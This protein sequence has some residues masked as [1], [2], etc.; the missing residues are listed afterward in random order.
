MSVGSLDIEFMGASW[1]RALRAEN[2]SPNTLKTYH[3]ALTQFQRFLSHG[4]PPPLLADI[5]REDVQAF[6]SDL[7][8]RWTPGTAHNRYR[9]LHSFFRWAVAEGELERS[10]MD[11]TRPPKVP[12]VPPS[13]LS[14]AQVRAFVKACEGVDFIDRRDMAMLYIFIDTGSRLGEVAGLRWDPDHPE[15]NDVDLDGQQLR[16]LGKG[17]RMRVVPIGARATRILD[18]YIRIRAR[19]SRADLQALWLGERG[20]LSSAGIRQ[21]LRARARR[22]GIPS[23]HP[24]LLRHTFAD[25]WLRS[26]GQEGDLMRITGWRSRA[27]LNRYAASTA[28]ARA[29]EAHRRLSPGDRL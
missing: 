8:A 18:R 28:A 4:G 25:N 29:L 10:P 9:A 11:N 21:A 19:H 5:D 6:M 1:L 2:V 15:T 26:G 3:A 17:S 16:V 7:L 12:E 14:P 23:F 27:M 22:A 20:A 24:H 13:V